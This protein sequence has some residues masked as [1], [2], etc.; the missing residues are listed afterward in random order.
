MAVTRTN[1]SSAVQVRGMS[2]AYGRL[3]AVRDLD[4]DIGHG[5]IFAILGPNG[6]G[7]STTIEIL[8]GHRKRNSGQVC[9]LGEDPATA[10]RSWR[11]QCCY[12]SSLRSLLR[13]ACSGACGA[14]DP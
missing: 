13:C 2:K 3:H 9:V 6:A 10:G 7:K 12:H 8:E 11:W 5:E 4:L 14:R 1:Q